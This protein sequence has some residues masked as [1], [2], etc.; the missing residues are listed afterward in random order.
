MID[1]YST[2]LFVDDNAS[3]L[4]AFFVTIIAIFFTVMAIVFLIYDQFVKRQNKKL[5]NMA[6]LTTALVETLFPKNVAHRLLEDAE[7]QQQQQQQQQGN[8]YN[9]GDNN[10]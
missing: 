3:S 5:A 7:V 2:N 8:N 10:C 6:T 4:P 9:N 1:L